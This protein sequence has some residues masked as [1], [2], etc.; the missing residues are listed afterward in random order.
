MRTKISYRRNAAR[1]LSLLMRG[2]YSLTELAE[3]T[4][5]DYE[6]ARNFLLDLKAEGV[7]HVCGWRRTAAKPAGSRPGSAAIR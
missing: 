4:P 2:Q 1:F 3:K 6:V 7:V 5:M